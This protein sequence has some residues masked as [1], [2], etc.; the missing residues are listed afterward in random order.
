MTEF[1]QIR[2]KYYVKFDKRE[3]L[4]CFEEVQRKFTWLC[5]IQFDNKLKVYEIWKFQFWKSMR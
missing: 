3:S 1:N 4:V 5:E 2:A